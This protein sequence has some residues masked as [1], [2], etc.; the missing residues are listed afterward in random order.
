MTTRAGLLREIAAAFATAGL[1]TPEREARALLKGGLG[2]ADID[3]VARADMAVSEED[4]ARLTI[5]ATRRAAGEPLARLIGRR[6]FWSLDFSLAPET[7]VPRPETE[8]L[9]EAALALFPDRTAPL[10]ILD[11]GTGT[12]AILAALLSE[13][14]NAF[15]LGVDLSEGAARQARDNLARLGLSGRSGVLVGRWAEAIHGRFDLVASNPPYI[16]AR[17]IAALDREVREHDPRLALDGGPDG[18]DA[19][20]VLAAALPGLLAPGGRAVLELGI[21]QESEVAQLLA[22]AGLPAD[23]PARRDL[24]GIARAIVTRPA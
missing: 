21:G 16:P 7:L 19:Y 5:L 6:E 13:Y 8:T 18:L 22:A 24:S 10:R 12:G 23:G 20:R 9:V 4:A 15:G 1:E 2:L 3:L 14:P 17:D 11:L